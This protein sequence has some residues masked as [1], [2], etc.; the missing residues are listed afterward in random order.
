MKATR[1]RRLR[2]AV[3]GVWQRDLI[4][5]SASFTT[6]AKAREFAGDFME[7]KV[8]R[9][10]MFP[11]SMR[12][13]SDVPYVL[14]EDRAH[15]CTSTVAR[16]EGENGQWVERPTRVPT[17]CPLCGGQVPPL[18]GQ[19]LRIEGRGLSRASAAATGECRGSRRANDPT[20]VE[21]MDSVNEATKQVFVTLDE[22]EALL[23]IEALE[24]HSYWQLSDEQYRRDG[25]ITGP[26]SDDPERAIA[27]R[28]AEA[29]GARIAVAVGTRSQDDATVDPR[30]GVVP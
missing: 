25:Y 20:E 28:V 22:S 12:C 16:W 14:I 27:I 10:P 24:S 17:H 13:G 2:F 29:L 8:P 26:G 21:A 18:G 1:P 3:S 15:G 23:L 9:H 7:R 11:A 6:E 5:E 30:T 19:R 4:G